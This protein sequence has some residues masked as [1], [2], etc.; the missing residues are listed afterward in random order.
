MYLVELD[1]GT[2]LAK[3]DGTYDGVRA[4]K[5]FREVINDPELGVEC[6]TAIALAADY[7]TPIGRYS[8]KDRPYKAMESVVGDR[9]AF[10]WD[11][12]KIQA[13]LIKY[14]ALQFDA[15]LEKKRTLDFMLLNKLE[16]IKSEVEDDN[17]VKLFKQLSTIE[18]LIDKFNNDTAGV[19]I[20][21][22]SPVRNGYTLRRLE[23]KILD[24]NSFYNKRLS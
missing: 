5:E 8:E 19:D 22:G 6:F 9:R 12:E 14:E 16:E 3:I 4:I 23:Q 7:L 2:G 13:C 11:Q 15:R 18:G 17:K 10:V 24:K 1:P 21:D 20:L